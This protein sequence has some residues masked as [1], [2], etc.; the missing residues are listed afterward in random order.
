MLELMESMAFPE[1]SQKKSYTSAH[2]YFWSF[3]EKS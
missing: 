3:E 2:S 1:P